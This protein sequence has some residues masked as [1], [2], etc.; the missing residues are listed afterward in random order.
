[1]KLIEVRRE[2]QGRPTS[3]VAFD[4]EKRQP[5]M[6]YSSVVNR[7]LTITIRTALLVGSAMYGRSRYNRCRYGATFAVYGS[8]YYGSCKY[9]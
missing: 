8:D 6:P 9:I 4:L 7:M 3:K 5:S 1:M 2:L